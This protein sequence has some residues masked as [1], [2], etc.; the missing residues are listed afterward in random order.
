VLDIFSGSATTGMVAL[1]N[2]R[3]YIGLDI[4]PKY[5]PLAESRICSNPPPEESKKS[6]ILDMF[7]G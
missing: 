3:N 6:P 1:Q 5:L 4:N 2:G 7:G